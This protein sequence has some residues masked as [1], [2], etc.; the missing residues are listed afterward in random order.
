MESNDDFICGTCF[1]AQ[2]GNPFDCRERS[3]REPQSGL[4]PEMESSQGARQPDLF[5]TE[6]EQRQDVGRKG[7]AL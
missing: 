4:S 7:A 5:R 2:L 1:I 6:I 3:H